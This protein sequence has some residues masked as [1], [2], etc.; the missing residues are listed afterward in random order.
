[1]N[2][3][4]DPNWWTLFCVNL[5]GGGF[6][7]K[8]DCVTNVYVPVNILDGLTESVKKRIPDL[9]LCS[10]VRSGCSEVCPSLLL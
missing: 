6:Y 8:Y 1:M 7:M 3:G 9:Y 5:K 2:Y 4:F 10:S